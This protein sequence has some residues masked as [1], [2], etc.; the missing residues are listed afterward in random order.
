MLFCLQKRNNRYSSLKS[1]QSIDC[2][3]NSPLEMKLYTLEKLYEKYNAHAM[4]ELCRFRAVLFT[5]I[6][7][8]IKEIILGTLLQK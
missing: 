8:V 7:F 2:N 5:T 1:I 4:C 3:A 6:F